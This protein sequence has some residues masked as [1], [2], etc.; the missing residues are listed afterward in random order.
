M[1]KR[2]TRKIVPQDYYQSL[3]DLMTV[4]FQN[5]DKNF[6]IV[7]GTMAEI[8]RDLKAENTTLKAEVEANRSKA[9]DRHVGLVKRIWF[10]AGVAVAIHIALQLWAAGIKK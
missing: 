7:H 6:E 9:D 4:Q 1:A 2:A 3:V 8:K 10:G 5:V